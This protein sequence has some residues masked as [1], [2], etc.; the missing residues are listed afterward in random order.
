MVKIKDFIARL[1]MGLQRH[2]GADLL[3]GKKTR[4]MNG[5]KH[6]EDLY[7]IEKMIGVKL[8]FHL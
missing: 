5:L 8:I 1:T 4:P 2:R 6:T 3:T 7:R